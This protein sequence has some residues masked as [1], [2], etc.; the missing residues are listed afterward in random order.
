MP[1]KSDTLLDPEALLN[2]APMFKEGL[3]LELDPFTIIL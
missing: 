2:H 1:W 3:A